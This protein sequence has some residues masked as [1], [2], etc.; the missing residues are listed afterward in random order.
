MKRIIL[1]VATN[2]A[3]VLVLG[4]VA[5]AVVG[6]SVTCVLE[7]RHVSGPALPLVAKLGGRSAPMVPNVPANQ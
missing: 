1:F 2:L 7:T 3:I 6:H 4:I 5:S